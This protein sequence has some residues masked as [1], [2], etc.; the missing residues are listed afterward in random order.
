[1]IRTVPD[2]APYFV[3]AGPELRVRAGLLLRAL[4]ASCTVMVWNPRDTVFRYLPYRGRLP[5]SPD[6]FSMAQV[7]VSLPDRTT[8]IARFKNREPTATDVDAAVARILE[9]VFDAR[10]AE[11]D[12]LEDGFEG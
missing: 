7:F 5:V 1:M 6:G 9:C 2:Y 10:T 3:D 8:Y 4:G 12:A 11:R